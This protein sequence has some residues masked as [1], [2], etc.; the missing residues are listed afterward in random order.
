MKDQVVKAAASNLMNGKIVNWESLK[1][2]TI[3][4]LDNKG[5]SGLPECVC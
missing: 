3:L 4:Y 2:P 5:L 1:K